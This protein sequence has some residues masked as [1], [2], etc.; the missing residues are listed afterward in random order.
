MEIK[1]V[2]KNGKTAVLVSPGFGAGWSTWMN[3]EHAEV[4]LYHPHIVD[5]VQAGRHEEITEEFCKNLLGI[6]DAGYVCTLGSDD[7]VI[8][9]VREGEAFE[10]TDYDGSES[11]NIISQ[12][13]YRTA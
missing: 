6:E 8:R 1:K 9:W 11:L 12:G 10:I 7:L 2:K 13:N 5:L 4:L 3:D